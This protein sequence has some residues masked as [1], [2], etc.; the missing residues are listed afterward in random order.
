MKNPE[1]ETIIYV[2][3]NLGQSNG[4]EEIS[5]IVPYQINRKQMNSVL[6]V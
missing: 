2:F 4:A 5:K 1:K 6:F 3:I